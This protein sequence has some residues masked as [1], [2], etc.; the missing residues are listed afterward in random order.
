MELEYE[1]VYLENNIKT[2]KSTEKMKPSIFIEVLTTFKF[3]DNA[4]FITTLNSV[5]PQS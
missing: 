2:K 1:L 5:H 3:V 4:A